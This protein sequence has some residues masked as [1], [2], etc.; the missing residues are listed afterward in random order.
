MGVPDSAAG[1][2]DWTF[3]LSALD[4]WLASR[5]AESTKVVPPA[6]RIAAAGQRTKWTFLERRGE[7]PAARRAARKSILQPIISAAP[8]PTR[9][10][11]KI[12]LRVQLGRPRAEHRS[13]AICRISQEETMYPA[14]MR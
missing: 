14:A 4:A 11:A 8:N 10:N 1:A 9:S 12:A 6:M 2:K 13:D 5:K 3:E 7:P